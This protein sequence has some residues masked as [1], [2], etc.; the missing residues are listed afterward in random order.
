MSESEHRLFLSK[1]AYVIIGIVALF[2]LVIGT[3][4]L[5]LGYNEAFYI[6]DPTVQ[7]V[8]KAISFT[9]EAI[10]MIILVAIF[11]IV[12]DKKFAKNLAFSLMFSVYLNEFLKDS[13]RDPRPATNISKDAEYGYVEPSYGFPSGHSQNA[14]A[15]WGYTGYRFKDEPKKNMIP[16][17]MSIL[18][19]LIALS[20]IIIGVHDLQDIVGGLLIGI[21]FL[22]IF[23]HL[24][25]IVSEKINP[26][27]LNVKI[28]IA[29]VVSITLAVVGTL[30]FPISGLGLVKSAPKYSDTGGYGQVGGAILGLSVG[31]L[32][33]N[34]Y[35]DYQPSRLTNKQKIINL[36]IGIVL[37]LV[38]YLVL[39]ALISG[40][41]VHRFIRYALLS[42]IVTFVAP[43]IFTKINRI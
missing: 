15:T 10:F 13:L 16:I 32:L 39:D 41:V 7:A 43:L 30:L 4:L 37:L 33:E 19:F 14:V 6:G 31:Y 36:I 9:G 17:I 1:S 42:F 11:Y 21:G 3:I 12:Y 24:E 5:L 35:I 23:I 25:P 29:I 2:I 8:F 27:N 38:L 34:E 20:R 22:M 40:T 18:I 26:L 28:L